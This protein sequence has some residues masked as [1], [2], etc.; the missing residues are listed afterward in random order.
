MAAK[1][2]IV[3]PTAEVLD[4]QLD[5][6]V[7]DNLAQDAVPGQSGPANLET[8]ITLEQQDATKLDACAK[9]GITVIDLD[10]IAFADAI[11]P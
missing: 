6:G 11:L 4:I 5:R 2:A 8:G 9:L 7:I 1:P 10:D 3:L